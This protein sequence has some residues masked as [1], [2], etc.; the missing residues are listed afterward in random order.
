M[1]ERKRLPMETYAHRVAR[2]S[3]NP[4]DEIILSILDSIQNFFMPQLSIA[5]E[6]G[7]YELLVLGIHAVIETISEHIFLR[8]GVPGLKFYLENFV[9]VDG[10]GEGFHYS[11]IAAD[12][13]DLRN[14]VA[15]QW[16]AAQGH[17]VGYDAEQKQGYRYEDDVLWVNPVAYF[18]QFKS[19][20]GDQGVTRYKLLEYKKLLDEASLEQVKTRFLRQFKGRPQ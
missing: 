6:K 12:L 14:N 15:H 8:P 2:F 7:L 5:S 4:P 20:F 13:N 3:N 16:F 1:S 18:Q 10:A 19:A 17:W 9:D 11:E